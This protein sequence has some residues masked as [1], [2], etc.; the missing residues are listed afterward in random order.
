MQYVIIR[1]T[2]RAYV[3]PHG[4]GHSYVRN[5]QDAAVFNLQEAAQKEACPENEIVIPR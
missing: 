3:A 1:V 5:L 4:S 2:D